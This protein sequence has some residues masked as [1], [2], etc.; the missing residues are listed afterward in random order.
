MFLN[1]RLWDHKYQKN[2]TNWTPCVAVRSIMIALKA[3][4]EIKRTSFRRLA[5]CVK[6]AA[7]TATHTVF[8]TH[9]FIKAGGG[10]NALV[11]E[12][13]CS[14]SGF[15]HNLPFGQMIDDHLCVVVFCL[16]FI[17]WICGLVAWKTVSNVPYLAYSSPFASDWGTLALIPAC[18]LLVW[19]HNSFRGT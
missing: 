16:F 1:T 15:K 14:M 4:T 5:S 10:T 6:L 12:H 2:C 9:D 7:A 8:L 13:S 3:L 19:F 18:K 17:K 11:T